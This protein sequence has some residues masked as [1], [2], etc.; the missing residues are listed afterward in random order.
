MGVVN[1]SH[2]DQ[3]R[4]IMT[5]LILTLL[6]LIFI[7]QI[8]LSLTEDEP[9]ELPSPLTKLDFETFSKDFKYGC[10][11][12]M[13]DCNSDHDCPRRMRCYSYLENDPGW[14]AWP[15]LPMPTPRHYGVCMRYW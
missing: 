3:D 7:F 9:I 13:V 1:Q 12:Y 10:H 11:K 14:P 15:I 8:Q 6:C 2:F 5:R 4:S